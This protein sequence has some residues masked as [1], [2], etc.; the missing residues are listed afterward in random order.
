M[1]GQELNSRLSS[2][3]PTTQPLHNQAT[4]DNLHIINY[5]IIMIINFIIILRDTSIHSVLNTQKV[6]LETVFPANHLHWQWKPNPW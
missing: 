4:D 3:K 5:I 6:T 1:L 2:R